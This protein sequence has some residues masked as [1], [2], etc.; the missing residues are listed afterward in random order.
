MNSGE[1]TLRSFAEHED[2]Q[3]A[4][5]CLQKIHF[6]FVECSLPFGYII[7]SELIVFLSRNGVRAGFGLAVK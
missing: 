3:T 6:M 5:R 4:A 1:S 7:N 2:Q